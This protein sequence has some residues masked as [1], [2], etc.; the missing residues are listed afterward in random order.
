[1]DFMAHPAPVHWLLVLGFIPFAEVTFCR[2]TGR[3]LGDLTNVL[4]EN[5]DG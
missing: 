1:M 3:A 4:A 2:R 5:N